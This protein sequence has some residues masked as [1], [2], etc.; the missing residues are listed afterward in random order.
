MADEILREIWR[1]KDE[2]AARFNHDLGAIFRY[3][4]KKERESGRQYVNL[5]KRPKKRRRSRARG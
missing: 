5:T 4:K 1:I 3:L 2:F